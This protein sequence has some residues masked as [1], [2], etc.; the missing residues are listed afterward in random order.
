[1]RENLVLRARRGRQGAV[2]FVR[3]GKKILRKFSGEGY[4]GSRQKSF[5]EW[6]LTSDKPEKPCPPGDNFHRRP[7]GLVACEGSRQNSFGEWILTS[8]KL[9]NLVPRAT[10]TVDARGAWL[11][12]RGAAESLS[13]NEFQRAASRKNLAL[14]AGEETVAFLICA[15]DK[16]FLKRF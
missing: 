13:V 7:E 5:G 9:E 14:R 2:F 4:G 11:P 1:M 10:T 6:I 8:D 12:A 3:A 16:N 15:G